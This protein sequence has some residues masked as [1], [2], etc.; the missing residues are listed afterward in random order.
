MGGKYER[1]R[2]RLHNYFRTAT[3]VVSSTT[4]MILKVRGYEVELGIL[5]TNLKQCS[6]VCP[7]LARIRIF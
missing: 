4:D 1:Y 6:F 3:W 2:S 5:L 7:T